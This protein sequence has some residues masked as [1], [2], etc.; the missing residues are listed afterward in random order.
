MFLYNVNHKTQE[1]SRKERAGKGTYTR[2]L[3][4][5]ISAGIRVKTDR[6]QQDIQTKTGIP[7]LQGIEVCSKIEATKPAIKKNQV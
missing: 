5:G 4:S 6:N 7:D 3:L 1:T 2:L